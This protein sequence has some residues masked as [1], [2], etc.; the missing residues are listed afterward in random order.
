MVGF[1]FQVDDRPSPLMS[2]FRIH[3][4]VLGV[5]TFKMPKNVGYGET[6]SSSSV[7]LN[8]RG[9]SDHSKCWILRALYC[10]TCYMQI[11]SIMRSPE[12]KRSKK[13]DLAQN[14][15]YR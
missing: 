7:V 10:G 2:S 12:V 6:K 5:H 9:T 1:N 4:F 3:P 13:F 8:D 11:N 15:V 14:I